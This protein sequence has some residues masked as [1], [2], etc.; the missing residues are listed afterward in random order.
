MS[1]SIS[2]G[3]TFIFSFFMAGLTG[4]YFGVYFL[5]LQFHNVYFI[6]I[7]AM[8][9]AIIFIMATIVIETTLYI[10][11]QNRD[12]KITKMKSK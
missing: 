7:Q 12:D 8:I 1:K 4:Y 2:F 6:N 9:I 11:K 3:M 5:G 10:I